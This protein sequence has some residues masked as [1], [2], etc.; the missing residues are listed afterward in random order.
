[1]EIF[2]VL[3]VLIGFIWMV[4]LFGSVLM[5]YLILKE[6]V[7]EVLSG[8]VMGWICYDMWCRMIR[9]VDFFVYVDGMRGEVWVILDKVVC[10]L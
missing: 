2:I 9:R 1:M 4:V 10:F 3:F 7:Y 8:V 6:C 5:W